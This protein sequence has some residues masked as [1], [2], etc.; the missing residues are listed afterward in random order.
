MDDTVKELQG[1]TSS[2][3]PPTAE[4]YQ[5]AETE[6][7]LRSQKQ[8]SPEDYKLLAPGKPVSPSSR[9]FTLAPVLN[10]TSGLIRWSAQTVG[11]C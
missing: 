11:G 1:A 3:T 6:I 5:Q 7:Q 8:S 4:D 2:N 10:L 9:L